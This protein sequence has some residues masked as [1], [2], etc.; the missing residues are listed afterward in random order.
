M[1]PTENIWGRYEIKPDSKKSVNYWKILDTFEEDEKMIC[2]IFER[3]L[4]FKNRQS[5]EGCSSWSVRE[6]ADG[7]AVLQLTTIV[8]QN[9]L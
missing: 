3:S 6:L 4:M 2:K 8:K 1:R 9:I 5:C 7:F